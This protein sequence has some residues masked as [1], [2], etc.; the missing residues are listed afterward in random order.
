MGQAGR[1]RGRS[2]DMTVASLQ[3]QCVGTSSRRRWSMSEFGHNRSIRAFVVSCTR[4]RIRMSRLSCKGLEANV[5]KLGCG[6]NISLTA[7]K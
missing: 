7:S 1:T 5:C 4:V 2:A 6:M 3:D